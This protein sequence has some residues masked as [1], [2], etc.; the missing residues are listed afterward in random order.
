MAILGVL[1]RFF[2]LPFFCYQNQMCTTGSI[3][4]ENK[5]GGGAGP[6]MEKIHN[7]GTCFVLT[8]S[9]TSR[10]IYVFLNIF[11]NPEPPQFPVLGSGQA[12]ERDDVLPGLPGG[13]GQLHRRGHGARGHPPHQ[14][15]WPPCL[16]SN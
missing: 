12:G 14:P 13:G 7:K 9:L 5:G 15:P 4:S 8:A 11:C 10:Q 3:T 16:G 6:L 2:F 1:Y